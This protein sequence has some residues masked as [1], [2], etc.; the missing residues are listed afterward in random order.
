MVVERV[1]V[2]RRAGRAPVVSERHRLCS[3]LDRL[4]ALTPRLRDRV[5]APARRAHVQR[6]R[7]ASGPMAACSRG[8]RDLRQA[9][10][11]ELLRRVFE[12]ASLRRPEQEEPSRLASARRSIAAC[13]LSAACRCGSTSPRPTRRPSHAEAPRQPLLDEQKTPLRHGRAPMRPAHASCL[14]WL[15]RGS[16]R[17]GVDDV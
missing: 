2:V 15:G 1:S 13:L 10:V 9:V 5:A 4:L 12:I 11:V 16:G 3:P 17:R 6:P 14:A 8:R 7:P